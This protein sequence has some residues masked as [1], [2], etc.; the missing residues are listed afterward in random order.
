MQITV[1]GRDQ[2]LAAPCS[3][4]ELL[5]QRGLDPQRV[6]VEHNRNVLLREEFESITLQDGDEL[7]IVQFVGGG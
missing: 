3:I 6:A 1:N 7:E 4:I 2:A 5:Q